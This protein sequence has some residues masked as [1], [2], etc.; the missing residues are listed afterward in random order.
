MVLEHPQTSNNPTIEN[1]LQ[2]QEIQANISE[3][4]LH[5]EAIYK[6]VIDRHRL[7]SSPNKSKFRVGNPV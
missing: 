4:L 2:H 1:I 7:Q 5:A 6:K 3:N